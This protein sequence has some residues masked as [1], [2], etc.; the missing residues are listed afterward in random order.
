M[1]LPQGRTIIFPSLS[2]MR[3]P[4]SYFSLSII[5]F[6]TNS[7]STAEGPMPT[8]RIPVLNN[9]RVT[10]ANNKELKYL[11]ATAKYMMHLP[12]KLLFLSDLSMR[13]HQSQHS[14]LGSTVERKW[15]SVS[16]DH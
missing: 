7:V 11:Q 12:A 15:F 4:G 13:A 5:D 8:M 6:L 16:T 2:L 10:L 3:D 1:N 9:A 14:K